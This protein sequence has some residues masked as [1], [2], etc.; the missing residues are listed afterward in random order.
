MLIGEEKLPHKLRIP[1]RGYESD[2]PLATEPDWAV[3]NPHEGL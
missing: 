3:T 2:D 1:M